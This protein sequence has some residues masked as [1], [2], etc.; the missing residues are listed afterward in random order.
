MFVIASGLC[1]FVAGLEALSEVFIQG[2]KF[3]DVKAQVPVS[4]QIHANGSLNGYVKK[5]VKASGDGT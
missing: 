3:D 5:P 1:I 2:I 4:K